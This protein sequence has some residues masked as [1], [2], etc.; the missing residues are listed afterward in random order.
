AMERLRGL[1]ECVVAA[2]DGCQKVHRALVNA[3]VSL[4]NLL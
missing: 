2:E 4:L 1:E 3:R